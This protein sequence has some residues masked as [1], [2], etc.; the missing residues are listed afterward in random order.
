MLLLFC[1]AAAIALRSGEY[2]KD[3]Y[4]VP[5]DIPAQAEETL[6]MGIVLLLVA[7]GSFLMW[8]MSKNS[9]WLAP[10]SAL[11][12]GAVMEATPFHLLNWW[13][14]TVT[15]ALVMVI[16][17]LTVH[18][19]ARRRAAGDRIRRPL[20]VGLI[21]MLIVGL[22][23]GAL[24]LI[25]A[26]APNAAAGTTNTPDL[27]VIEEL[28]VHTA[29]YSCAVDSNGLVSWKVA[30][31]PAPGQDQR[32]W[33]YSPQT[34]FVSTDPAGMLAEVQKAVCNDPVFGS[35]VANYFANL[36]LGTDAVV[37]FNPWLKPFAGDPKIVVAERAGYYLPLR[38]VDPKNV[39]SAQ[40]ADA[41]A[42]NKEWQGVANLVNTLLSRPHLAGVHAELSVLSYRVA[43]G[44]LI[45]GIPVIELSPTQ[46][47]L[48]ALILVVDEKQV[49]CILRMGFNTGDKRVE[50]FACTTPRIP[51]TPTTPGTPTHPGTP[52]GTTPPGGCTTNCVTTPPTTSTPTPSPTCTQYTSSQ[53]GTCF[54]GKTDAPQPSGVSTPSY[55]PPGSVSNTPPPTKAT[56]LQPQPSGGST[57]QPTAPGATPV[58]SYSPPPPNT[59]APTGPPPTT[60]SCIFAC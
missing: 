32:K 7:V 4:T 46:E 45:A 57:S 24:S 41:A 18:A 34:P 10:A 8:P 21:L 42:K 3:N 19:I 30:T 13:R 26:S 15:S 23:A 60:V 29:S 1:C 17:A 5:S 56:P 22:L 33:S 16:I 38:N 11:G 40:A 12:A 6:M 9:Y 27:S 39:T 49:G 51:G 44:N 25:G 59:G 43:V 2:V 48:P 58:P 28:T 37:D 35:M 50:Q 47:S 36:K 14:G 53:K 31:L 55:N 52:P 20:T 54:G